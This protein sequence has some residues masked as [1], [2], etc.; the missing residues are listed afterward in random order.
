MG[1][2]SDRVTIVVMTRD[3][4][5][6]LEKT[7]PLHE[8]PVILV[9]NG[10]R[11]GTPALVREHHPDVDVV[12]LHANHGSTARN[13]GVERA[14]T[15]YVAFADDDSWWAP[16]A[17]G[18]AAD[19]L[20]AHPRLAVLAA[21]MLVGEEETP[22]TICAEMADS[23]LGQDADLPGPSVLGFLACGAVVR[24]DAY[25]SAGGFDDV[26]FFMGEEERLALDLA[27][28]GWGLAYVDDVVAHH[29]PSPVR[30][31]V[32]RAARAAR[33][34]LLTAVMRRPWPVVL[35]TAA[36]AARAGAPGRSAL[37]QAL[38]VV[39]R[40]LARR[41]RLPVSVEAARRSLDR[42]P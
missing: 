32:A 28:T 21:R 19:V 8:A 25:L 37:R 11:D 29:H 14:R 27:A 41:R 2:Q 7:L 31:P 12:E 6:D 13:I 39:P 42:A 15:P 18:R 36:A 5:P 1:D 26:V 4:W 33:N 10:S 34:E 17:L 22:D 35:R 23:P 24:R 30:D 16:G 40:A 9:D 38:P 20:D 3:R